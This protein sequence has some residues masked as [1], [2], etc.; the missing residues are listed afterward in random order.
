M[1]VNNEVWKSYLKGESTTANKD[2]LVTK[3]DIITRYWYTHVYI[4]EE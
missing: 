2:G 3:D 4:G 1:R